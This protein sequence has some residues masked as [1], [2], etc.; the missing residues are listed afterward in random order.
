MK[1]LILSMLFCFGVGL[2]LMASPAQVPGDEITGGGSRVQSVTHVSGQSAGTKDAGR[3]SKLSLKIKKIIDSAKPKEL[4][5]GKERDLRKISAWPQARA[6]STNNNIPDIKGVGK[7]PT[8]PVKE[9]R[10]HVNGKPGRSKFDM[11]VAGGTV[12]IQK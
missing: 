9:E 1:K 10:P 12:D 4:K 5:S 3:K 2:A 8:G 7:H 11:I 6:N